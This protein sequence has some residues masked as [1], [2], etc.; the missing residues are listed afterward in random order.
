MQ[1]KLDEQ[2]HAVLQDGQPVYLH[3][4][5]KEIAF[6]AAGTLATIARLNRERDDA[7]T[8]AEQALQR[9]KGFDGIADPDAARE[10]LATVDNLRHKKLVD[11]GEIEQVKAEIGKVFE[12]RLAESEQRAEQLQQQLVD[13]RIGGSFARSAFI[14]NKL[15]IPADMA[16]AFFGSAFQLEDGRIVAQDAHGERIYSRARPGELAEF[17]EALEVLVER[18]PQRDRILKGSGSSGLDA[19]PSGNSRPGQRTLA[20]SAFDALAPLERA[21][22]V[23]GGGRVVA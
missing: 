15:A 19:A 17:D 18:Y 20:R 1:L 3:P 21:Q 13:E 4:D 10:A 6:D 9:L 23:Q 12:A 8:Q 5:G 2:G 7:R 22:F 11:A 14:T 16:R